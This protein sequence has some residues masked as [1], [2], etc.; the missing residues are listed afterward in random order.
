MES[1]EKIAAAVLYEGYLLWPYRRSAVK[2]QQRW[3]FGGVYP[4]AYSETVDSNDPWLMRT[5]CLVLGGTAV[6]TVK[7]RFLH[8]VDRQVGRQ[9]A[10]GLLEFVDELQVGDERF[11]TWEEATER[12]IVIV[13]L[14]LAD[15]GTAVQIPIHI[16]AGSTMEPL[17]AADGHQAGALLR[18][19]CALDAWVKIRATPLPGDVFRL[20]VTITNH[21]PWQGQSRLQTL[22]Q[23]LVST[24]TILTVTDGAF[25]SLTDPPPEV[26]PLA[27]ACDNIKTW[28]VLAGEPG[29]THTILSSPIILADYPQIAPESPGDLFDGSEIDQLLVLNILSL[30]DEEKA[31][32]RATDPRVR[33]ILARTEALTA[34]DFMQLHGTMREFR[35]LNGRSNEPLDIPTWY[36][37]LEK[38]A[39]TSVLVNN[40][41]IG[42]GSKVRLRPRPGG[43]VMDIVLAGKVAFIETIEQDY[44][45]KVHL[46]VTLEDDPGRDLG[47]L[48]QPGHRFFF[49]PEEV[50]PLETQRLE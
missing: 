6:T 42:P 9:H 49:A 7:I 34:D 12:E 46:T 16:P 14:P 40:V 8:V 36:E 43:D 32:I 38:P 2:N 47:L 25:V 20:A 18:S 19:W 31:E 45:D 24:H 22:K 29:D 44:D 15:L 30:T 37:E 28:P 11:F 33:E 26:R 27:E 41:E 35:M 48:H 17:L 21:T 1:V 3:T 10:S 39:P 13:D 50:E 4:R 23:T 5:E